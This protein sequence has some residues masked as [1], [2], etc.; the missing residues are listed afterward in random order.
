MNDLNDLPIDPD[1]EVPQPSPPL[2]VLLRQH[3][4]LLPVIAAGGGAGS[5][6]RWGLDRVI[7]GTT[8]PWATFTINLSGC[9]LIGLLMAF[10]LELWSQRRY[11]RPLVGVGFLGGFTT[12]STFAL[13]TRGLAASSHALLAVV[14]VVASVSLGLLAAMAGL[15]GGRAAIE[16]TQ[17]T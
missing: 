13:E 7:A 12:F 5:L 3:V 10:V 17:A 2:G 4:G 8:Y 14:Y 6:A 15:L 11:V 1:V 9:L 16:R